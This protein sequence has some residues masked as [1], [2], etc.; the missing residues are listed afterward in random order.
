MA[1]H[2][3]MAEAMADVITDCKITQNCAIDQTF[4]EE[5]A[6]TQLLMK[7]KLDHFMKLHLLSSTNLPAAFLN[8]LECKPYQVADIDATITDQPLVETVQR[9][10]K[11]IKMQHNKACAN[12]KL[13]LERLAYYLRHELPVVEAE[14]RAAEAKKQTTLMF[15]LSIH[16]T[17]L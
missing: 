6:L 15:L 7:D 11:Q 5:W 9:G 2:A 16:A 4:V 10:P 12:L 1:V 14:K 13:H 3:A 17:A 8:K